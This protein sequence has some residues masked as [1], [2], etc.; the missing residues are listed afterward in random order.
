[1]G[2]SAAYVSLFCGDSGKAAGN[3]PPNNTKPNPGAAAKQSGN[4]RGARF[5]DKGPDDV[6]KMIADFDG[7][8]KGGEENGDP[9][10][11]L[12]KAEQ[13]KSS[14]LNNDLK[15]AAGKATEQAE[16]ATAAEKKAADVAADLEKTKQAETA[17]RKQAEESAASIK[18]LNTK[19]ADAQ[20]DG[21]AGA[22]E[23]EKL[24]SRLEDADTKQAAT[25][26]QVAVAIEAR[27]QAESVLDAAAKKLKD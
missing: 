9:E 5:P 4:E 19:L 15:P 13:A 16:K 11:D 1:I 7:G 27:K 25:E 14:T 8:K 21:L 3:T 23:I 18:E 17:A 20:K 26:K 24:K 22:K 12:V 6:G 2:G 10:A